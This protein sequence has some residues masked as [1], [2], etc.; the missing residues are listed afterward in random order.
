MPPCHR[1][2]HF[3]SDG[4][5]SQS[6]VILSAPWGLILDHAQDHLEANVP[7]RNR[8]DRLEGV[9]PEFANRCRLAVALAT[10]EG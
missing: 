1:C 3:S 8:A 5:D 7:A 9:R 6:S 2:Q 4:R 10:Q